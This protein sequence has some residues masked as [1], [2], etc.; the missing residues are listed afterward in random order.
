MTEKIQIPKVL[1]VVKELNNN[2]YTLLELQGNIEHSSL[3][4]FNDLHLGTLET[5]DN[6]NYI[7]KIGNHILKGKRIEL[8]V[9]FCVCK[10]CPKNKGE[11]EVKIIKI[12]KS[13]ILFNLRP[14][15][16]FE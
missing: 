12:I 13:K 7:F 4:N 2:E 16:V 15:P 6:I 11:N 14:T 10:K 5:E 8:K 9:P 3:H 1:K